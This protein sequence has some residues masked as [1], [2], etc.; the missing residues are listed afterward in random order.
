MRGYG[1]DTVSDGACRQGIS[2]MKKD[3]KKYKDAL[4]KYREIMDRLD[5]QWEYRM[6]VIGHLN[7]QIHI[8]KNRIKNEKEFRKEQK[9]RKKNGKK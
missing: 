1:I 7:E 9:A 2:E 4:K 6:Q 3:K 8:I 5:M